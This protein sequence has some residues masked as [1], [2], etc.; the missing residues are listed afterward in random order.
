MLYFPTGAQAH[1]ADL[2]MTETVGVNSS[3]LTERA[4]L[5]AYEF[6]KKR[7]LTRD[8][9][10]LVMCGT[11]NN[12]GDGLALSRILFVN[13]YDV[14]ILLTGDDEK[15]SAENSSQ[16]KIC[17]HYNIPVIG[18]DTFMRHNGRSDAC[19]YDVIVDALI[20]IGL[21]RGIEGDMLCAIE[22]A[23]SRGGVKVALDVP[24]GVKDS[25]GEVMSRAFTSD[26][27]LSMGYVKRGVM[28]YPGALYAGEV[29]TCDIGITDDVLAAACGHVTFGFDESDLS[30]IYPKRR[31]DANKGDCGNVLIVAGRYGMAGAACLC[32]SAAYA[33]GAGKVCVYTADSNRVILQSAVPEAVVCTYEDSFTAPDE[34]EKLIFALNNAD[35]VCVGCGL[36]TDDAALKILTTVLSFVSVPC[37]VDADAL[38]LIA[39]D[40]NLLLKA[41]APLILTPHM[42]E[43]SRLTGRDV[44][45]VKAG[46]FGILS[47][48]T[49]KYHVTCVLKDA[50]TLIKSPGRAAY[51]NTSGNAA[52][53]K[54]GAGD[55]LSGII[56][57]IS[58]QGKEAFDAA[59]AGAYVHGLAGMKAAKKKGMHGVLAG[60]I[61]SALSDVLKEGLSDGKSLSL[62]RK[63]ER[64]I[65]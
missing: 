7:V 6:L 60:D 43:M 2:Y 27:T 10:I 58:G 64:R 54:A 31:P 5:S 11:G 9:R 39:K 26:Y 62:P 8:M 23:N 38:N 34:E 40:N 45:A 21:N 17:R 14:T 13:G 22:E 28:M 51:L 49:E 36:G 44:S 50:R 1:L 59:C 37:V 4:A 46:R 15:R 52:M 29:I 16:L 3:V 65:R 48:F 30:V 32:A 33:A 42:K 35:A 12:G 19:R 55:V 20:G 63:D 53:A 57:G 25:T 41:K 47:E 56:T 61:V 18:I 24:T